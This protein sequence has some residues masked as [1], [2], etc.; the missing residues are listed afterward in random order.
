MVP[1]TSL[2]GVGDHRVQLRHL[3]PTRSVLLPLRRL[4]LRQEL[5]ANPRFVPF[6]HNVRV[7]VGHASLQGVGAT[8]DAGEPLRDDC[9]RL[10]LYALHTQGG[11][12]DERVVRHF[13]Q[14]RRNTHGL[15]GGGRPLLGQVAGVNHMPQAVGRRM[16]DTETSFCLSPS[17]LISLLLF[18]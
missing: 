15:L 14:V 1:R 9:G 18:V 17:S 13:S 7:V 4:L 11:V 8:Q 10:L 16:C 6:L 2:E 12:L 5:R 3:H